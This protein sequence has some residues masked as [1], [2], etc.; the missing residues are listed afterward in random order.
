[1]KF[2]NKEHKERYEDVLSRMTSTD[3]YHTSVAYLMSLDDNC[4]KH[5]NDLFDFEDDSIKADGLNKAWNTS[6][7]LKV[8]RLAF[9]LWNGYCYDDNDEVDSNFCVDNIFNCSYA[10]YFY[11]AIKLRYPGCFQYDNIMFHVEHCL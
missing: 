9:N 7:T 8:I 11:Q 4:Y 3:N 5:I 1:M 10:E 6:T 2:Y